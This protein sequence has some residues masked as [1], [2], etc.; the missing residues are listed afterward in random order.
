MRTLVFF[1]DRVIDELNPEANLT[2][3]EVMKFFNDKVSKFF[4]CNYV[5]MVCPWFLLYIQSCFLTQDTEV[6]NAEQDVLSISEKFSDPVLSHVY[7]MLKKSLF[8]VNFLNV[9]CNACS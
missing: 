1:I 3:Q 8:K 5:S 9:F 2:K 4:S 6:Q 7:E